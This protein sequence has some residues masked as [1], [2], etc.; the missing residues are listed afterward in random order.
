[1]NGLGPPTCNCAKCTTRKATTW[2]SVD[3]TSASRG[4]SSPYCEVCVLKE[5]IAHARERAEELPKLEHRLAEL[6]SAESKA[7]V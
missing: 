6:L 3:G 4:Y 1:M 5:Q 7:D 2:F